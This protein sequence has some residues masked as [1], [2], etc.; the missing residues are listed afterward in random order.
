MDLGRAEIQRAMDPLLSF[1]EQLKE[2]I[3]SYERL[4]RGQFEE[5]RNFSGLGRLLIAVRITVTRG[6]I[7]DAGLQLAIG[8]ERQNSPRRLRCEAIAQRRNETVENRRRFHV[9]H[10]PARRSSK[11]TGVQPN[12]LAAAIMA[13]SQ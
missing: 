13:A 6:Q 3:E 2:E 8:F 7:I 10:P 12:C 4:K 5:I 11:P 1:H 9:L